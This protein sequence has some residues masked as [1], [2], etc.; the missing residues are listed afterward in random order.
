MC[1]KPILIKNINHGNTS[2][3]A[4][5][6][7]TTSQYIPVPC[8]RCS[9]CLS[10]KQ[11]YLVQRVQMES[12]SHDLYF[13]TLTYNNDMLPT[14]DVCDY[15][16]AYPDISDWQ[17]MIKMIRKHENLK[18]RYFLV[19]EYGGRKHRPHFHFILSFP[20]DDR[21]SLAE[22]W[23]FAQYLS[24]VFLRYWRRNLGSSR[25]PVWKNLCT[26]VRT[27][28]HYNF[29]LHYLDSNLS[30]SGHDDI[31]FYVTKYCLKYDK[32]VDKLK[33]SL[34]FNL[35][36]DTYKETWQNIK[37]RLLLSKGFG[38]PADP[39]V[40]EHINKGI[41]VALQ[42]IDALFPYFISPVNG[43]SFPLAPYYSKRFLT[44]D[45]M[46]VF[47]S[48]KPCL[49]DY[50]MFVDTTKDMTVAQ[51]VEKERRFNVVRDYLNDRHTYFDEN[52]SEIN[53]FLIS[54]LYGNTKK[55]STDSQEFADAWQDT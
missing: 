42:D 7:D 5:F 20:K 12:L 31:A 26:Y 14:L 34:F 48:R 47:N 35:D 37:P 32:W 49:T 28:K 36:A 6:T 10:L 30:S 29:D 40:I 2:K 21:Q 16:L 1:L 18:F 51:I 52:S 17:K 19:S 13:G 15:H 9:V 53:N 55:L 38:S 45:D 27:R 11:Q 43:A 22:R 41:F 24:D 44:F 4:S 39:K 8:G 50:D 33:S 46:L 23:S 54:N 25:S 3:F